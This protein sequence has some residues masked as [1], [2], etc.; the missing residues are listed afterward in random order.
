MITDATSSGPAG[1]GGQ[2]SSGQASNGQNAH[3]GLAQ[4]F[5][6][7]LKLL[8][9][10]LTSQDPL[11]PLNANEF[12]AQL[13]QFTG[14]EQAIRTNGML[15]ELLALSRT[16]Q[17]ARGASYIGQE[18]EASGATVRLDQD[19]TAALTYSLPGTAKEV[20]IR[21]LSET[22]DLV[23]RGQGDAQAGPHSIPWNGLTLNG[24]RAPSGLYRVEI[25]ATDR[26][27]VPVAVERSINGTV[28]GVEF[29]GDGRMM[30]SV[31]GVLIPVESITALRR[32]DLAA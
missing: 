13:V 6:N 4:N 31:G 18:V 26:N 7:F 29:A 11:E 27:G 8:T 2:A 19:R 9:T 17:F 1:A 16:D 20:E 12:T 32:P 25:A 23:W 24:R 5:D 15:N 10:Q 28:V 3:I 21:I 30:I 22:G 14:V